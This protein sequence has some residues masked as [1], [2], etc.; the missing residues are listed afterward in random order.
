MT[1]A[2]L[3]NKLESFSPSLMGLLAR[4]G[5]AA[6]FFRSARTKVN[7]WTITDSTYY[8]F[9]EEYALPLLDPTFAAQLATIAEHLLPVMLVLGLGARFGAAGLLAMTAM[10][11]FFVYPTSWPTHLLWAAPLVY[12]LAY[13]PGRLSVDHWIRARF[14]KD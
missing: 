8:L 13:G 2:S 3:I 12:V 6:V 4:L 9:E 10:I 14:L 1:A 7:D 11:Q 5:I